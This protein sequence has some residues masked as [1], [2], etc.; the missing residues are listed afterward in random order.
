MADN[1]LSTR[2][3]ELGAD[4]QLDDLDLRRRKIERALPAHFVA[5]Y[6][7]FITFLAVYYEF[8][9][10]EDGLDRM[11]ERL[12]DVRNADIADDI[13]MDRLR[14][15]YGE[16]F[17]ENLALNDQNA[18]KIFHLWFKSKG[19]QEAIRA[20]FKLFLNSDAEVVYPKDNML[21]VSAGNWDDDAQRWIDA[22]GHL[23]ETT[24]VIQ[25]SNY[26]QIYSYLVR[27][28]VS[29]VDWGDQF[30][31]L[32]HPAGW[33][34]FGEVRIEGLAQFEQFREFTLAGTRSPTIVPGFQTKDANILILSSALYF[35]VKN[36]AASPINHN[37]RTYSQF[38]RKMYKIVVADVNDWYTLTNVN[39]NLLVSTHT[40]GELKDYQLNE[41]YDIS[42]SFVIKVQNQRPARILTTNLLDNPSFESDTTDWTE[43]LAS[44]GTAVVS[45]GA[46]QLTQTSSGGTTPK[47]YQTLNLEVGETY[48]VFGYALTDGDCTATIAVNN[49]ASGTSVL[50]ANVFGS[51]ST[52]AT[53]R[54]FV[55][56]TFTAT[57]ATHNLIVAPTSPGA[58]N[59]TATFDY[60]CVRKVS[61]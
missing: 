17:P 12:R 3:G 9:E 43:A 21:R 61:L 5:E 6:P 37:M 4:F 46:L 55:A 36:T 51:A 40:I 18:L 60:I 33:K 14:E 27:S 52:T 49:S 56:M 42:L 28:G 10:A 39:K 11:I 24:M 31:E 44:N 16:G 34:L 38:I 54:T 7:D 8:L 23:S 53:T 48:V 26:Y 35:L 59:A 47:V 15:E 25:D 20:Y 32:A 41:L 13:Y 29:I 2:R 19:N 45:G 58:N 1:N 22:D 30:R 50:P 57:Q